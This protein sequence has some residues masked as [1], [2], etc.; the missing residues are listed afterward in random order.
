[1]WYSSLSKDNLALENYPFFKR[2]EIMTFDTH[3]GL[4]AMISLYKYTQRHFS[5]G[6]LFSLEKTCDV[7][8]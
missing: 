3:H 8:C 4:S 6:Y 5:E 1:M 2:M 7:D